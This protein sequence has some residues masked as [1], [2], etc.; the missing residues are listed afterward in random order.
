MISLPSSEVSDSEQ[1]MNSHD[2]AIHQGSSDF[3]LTS[4]GAKLDQNIRKFDCSGSLHST[5]IKLGSWTKVTHSILSGQSTAKL[6]QEQLDTEKK[7]ALDLLDG[8]SRSGALR[9]QNC[10]FHVLLTATHHFEQSLMESIIQGNKNPIS[11][12]CRSNLI[13]ART[14][15]D[16]HI[17]RKHFEVSSMFG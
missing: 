13:L 17:L 14:V 5:K 8:L 12:L 4:L 2:D 3:D 7:K 9:I 15:H 16:T 1:T 11:D 10:S 6:S